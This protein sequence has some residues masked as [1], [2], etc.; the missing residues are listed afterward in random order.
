MKFFPCV[1]FSILF[2]LFPLSSSF[3]Q[4]DPYAFFQWSLK[5]DG[6]AIPLVTD[7]TALKGEDLG[8][9][10]YA[11]HPEK[12]NS[13]LK[14]DVVV[15]ILD[16]GLDFNHP[17]IR[18][19][20]AF[21]LADC[22]GTS[23]ENYTPSEV[24]KDKN[25]YVGDCFGWNFVPDD[26]A[27]GNQFPRDNDGH[28]THLA[29]IISAVKGNGYGVSSVSNHVKIL[30]LRVYAYVNGLSPE[31]ILKRSGE[32]LKDLRL[33]RGDII[34]TAI[35]YAIS[36][37]VDVI[38]LSFG[39]NNMVDDRKVIVA[40]ASAMKHGIMVVAA[41]GN[42]GGTAF[43]KPCIYPGVVCVGGF[44]PQ[45]N[46]ARLSNYGDWVDLYAPGEDILSLWPRAEVASL[47][48][49][50]GLNQDTGT[51]Q[52]SA[53][54]SLSAAILKSIYP[55]ENLLKT[56][57]RLF[58]SQ[59]TFPAGNPLTA[60]LVSG[61]MHLETAINHLPKTFYHPELKVVD[62]IIVKG[63]LSFSVPILLNFYANHATQIHYRWVAENPSE[64]SFCDEA[65]QNLS[66]TLPTDQ[67]SVDLNFCGKLNSWDSN[68]LQNFKLVM[69][70]EIDG[71][72]KTKT[73]HFHVNFFT[74]KNVSQ[75][76][77]TVKPLVY[78][79][80]NEEGQ[81]IRAPQLV[82]VSYLS[83]SVLSD[84]Q[85]EFSTQAFVKVPTPENPKN[86][87]FKLE[88]IREQENNYQKIHEWDL[89]DFKQFFGIYKIDWKKNNHQEYIIFGMV[90]TEV[91]KKFK[92]FV[93]FQRFNAKF[94]LIDQF[95]IP[96]E[97]L[98]YDRSEERTFSPLYFAR[99]VRFSLISNSN[100]SVS[101]ST[102]PTLVVSYIIDRNSRTPDLQRVRP[103]G[104]RIR[105]NFNRPHL[106]FF[107]SDPLH[108][109]Q[110]RSL[111]SGTWEKSLRECLGLKSYETI[112]NFFRTSNS[113]QFEALSI[114]V[115]VQKN[116]SKSLYYVSIDKLGVDAADSTL[117]CHPISKPMEFNKS[118]LSTTLL[119]PESATT[120]TS[121][122]TIFSEQ[123]GPWLRTVK[124]TNE[125]I[126][127]Y[128][129][130]EVSSTNGLAEGL[131]DIAHF[132]FPH[133]PTKELYSFWM[134]R[135]GLY[136]SNQL[137]LSTTADTAL[138]L[139]LYIPLGG[140]GANQFFQV[141]W[142]QVKDHEKDNVTK[143]SPALTYNSN[144]M[145]DPGM[146]VFTIETLGQAQLKIK[147]PLS[148]QNEWDDEC[149]LLSVSTARSNQPSSLIYYCDRQGKWT[150]ESDILQLH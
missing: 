103:E 5:N 76:R 14:R 141:A 11:L 119:Y 104:D 46:L 33:S 116:S 6:V 86:G 92:A 82:P 114:Y 110:I 85:M 81:F 57:A 55:E 112:D 44:N 118:Q 71:V 124:L 115:Q 87:H 150:I 35:N 134:G 91:E 123:A 54:L 7:G 120:K 17:D 69:E 133:S 49:V 18:N 149:R 68:P 96:S 8:L 106:Y 78:P 89:S 20:L 43:V 50:V 39:Y 142:M 132:Y 30:P 12:L 117:R 125:K 32:G 66:L 21:N 48:P 67:S 129:T 28:G 74:S 64:V 93:R 70:S 99:G 100:P 143:L 90:V 16:T 135:R 3:A 138:E 94:E 130:Q 25:G 1:S 128:H 47:F 58:D 56:K 51:S 40:L 41:A 36:R 111:N 72:S 148:F 53:Y 13:L 60:N 15:A 146:R 62:H 144:L 42:D 45:G 84:S 9:G 38:N 10:E 61:K 34:A 19:N 97:D 139:P 137:D 59:R 105:D 95:E 127:D 108:P 2:F 27:P 23:P 140:G 75:N 113:I 24:D 37:K 52:A 73:Y 79:T 102:I 145:T 126:E 22:E 83:D 26:R 109:K 121:M 4:N 65:N 63:D 147:S 98:L 29:G 136:L 122:A 131:N 77:R 88:L 107:T 80:V 101:K 31:F